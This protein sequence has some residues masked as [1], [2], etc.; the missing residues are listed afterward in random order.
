LLQYPLQEIE[1]PGIVRIP[2][3]PP[4]AIDLEDAPCGP[5]VDRWVHVAEV[6]LVGRQL[7]VRMGVPNLAKLDQLLL[8]EF[9]VDECKSHGVEGQIPGGEPGILPLIRH[10]ENRAAVDVRPIGI[11]PVTTLRRRWRRGGISLQPRA[12]VVM[13]ELLAPDHS[14]ES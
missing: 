4:F 2:C 1:I 12:Y 6:P 13:V 3:A 8:G 5:G 10:G 9:T 14:S 7:A 11:A